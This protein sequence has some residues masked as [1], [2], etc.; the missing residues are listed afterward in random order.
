M[1]VKRQEQNLNHRNTADSGID[2]NIHLKR[3]RIDR[4]RY[5]FNKSNLPLRLGGACDRPLAA[6]DQLPVTDDGAVASNSKI[7]HRCPMQSC[8][9]GGRKGH[10]GA[11]PFQAHDQI[12]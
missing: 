2:L 5:V 11:M 1:T 10:F 6:G 3:G 7:S 8:D 9:Y 4:V 12:Q